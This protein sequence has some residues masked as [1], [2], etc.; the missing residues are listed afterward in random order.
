MR[1]L[2]KESERFSRKKI[3][4]SP[5]CVFYSTIGTNTIINCN[6]EDD[7][8][9]IQLNLLK[10]LKDSFLEMAFETYIPELKKQQS[11]ECYSMNSSLSQASNH[12]AK[13]PKYE[14][15]NR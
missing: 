13:N 11:I 5:S 8:F 6:Q 15:I 2:D 3:S 12:Q 14:I 10:D 1:I 9:D 7:S 4:T